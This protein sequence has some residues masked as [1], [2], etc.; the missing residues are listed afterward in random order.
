M[1]GPIV[2]KY[3]FPNFEQIFGKKEPQHGVDETATTPAEP[4][5]DAPEP[6]TEQ[7]R[8]CEDRPKTSRNAT[9][10][11]YEV[12]HV[13]RSCRRPSRRGASG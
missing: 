9:T 13:S 3:G 4:P 7:G 1:S 8:S 5:K 10:S 11:S 6:E 2:R 12:G